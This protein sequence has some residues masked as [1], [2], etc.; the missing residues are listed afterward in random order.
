[1]R[2]TRFFYISLLITNVAKIN[3]Q[4]YKRFNARDVA[5]G[6]DSLPSQK[7]DGLIINLNFR[8]CIGDNQQKAIP[9]V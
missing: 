8:G 6:L 2:I 5:G 7:G 4:D 9:N 3:Y 1:M